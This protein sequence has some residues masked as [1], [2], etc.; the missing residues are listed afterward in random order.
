MPNHFK[1]GNFPG[2]MKVVPKTLQILRIQ[3]HLYDFESR[4]W[5]NPTNVSKYSSIVW[6]QNGANPD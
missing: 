2:T 6:F 4:R 3:E 1:K 5:F